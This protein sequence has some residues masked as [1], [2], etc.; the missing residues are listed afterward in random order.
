[1]AK[2]KA[3]KKIR[4]K[5]RMMKNCMDNEVNSFDKNKTF[6]F[7]IFYESLFLWYFLN[8]YKM[9]M[10]MLKPKIIGLFFKTNE[11]HGF[12]FFVISLFF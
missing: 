1:M 6:A 12:F 5:M 4:I 7:K 9:L 8:A 3:T 11:V 2:S 10:I